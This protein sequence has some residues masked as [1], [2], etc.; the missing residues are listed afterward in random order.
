MNFAA[1]FKS[2]G[3]FKLRWT[4]QMVSIPEDDY[5][6]FI[7]SGSAPFIGPLFTTT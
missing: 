1:V 4:C 7:V 3:P 2:A 6:V 5:S